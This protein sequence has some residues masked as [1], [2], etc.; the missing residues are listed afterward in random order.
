MDQTHTSFQ[1]RVTRLALIIAAATL[2]A[3]SQQ[4]L[5]R[6]L[7]LSEPVQAHNDQPRPQ[8]AARP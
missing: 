3:L 2:V 7:L 5:L 1:R 6:P 8:E 4:V